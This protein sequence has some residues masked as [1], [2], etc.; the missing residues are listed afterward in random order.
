VNR[1]SRDGEAVRAISTAA[2][3]EFRISRLLVFRLMKLNV[4][5]ILFNLWS[6]DEKKDIREK[7]GQ[8]NETDGSLTDGERVFSRSYSAHKDR[9]GDGSHIL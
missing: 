7:K 4:S 9:N 2:V 6:I 5:Y 3:R 8:K 1:T